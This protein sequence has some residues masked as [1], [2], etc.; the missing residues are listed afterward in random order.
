[1]REKGHEVR[2]RARGEMAIIYIGAY[3]K[4]ASASLC[5]WFYDKTLHRMYVKM[6]FQFGANGYTDR[7]TFSLAI[8]LFFISIFMVHLR[9]LFLSSRVSIS[10]SAKS[11]KIL[12]NV[13]FQ[14]NT[15]YDQ[16]RCSVSS[17]KTNS[18]MKCI[19]DGEAM[20]GHIL[21]LVSYALQLYLIREFFSFTGNYNHTL[22]EPYEVM[23]FVIFIMIATAVHE[24]SCS[25]FYTCVFISTT[26]ICLSGFIFYQ[27]FDSNYR[28]SS[29]K[30]HDI[31]QDQQRLSKRNKN[32]E[33]RFTI[34]VS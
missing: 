28:Y 12:P 31:S 14:C 32:H 22:T 9:N 10:P 27:F 2:K 11:H 23:V 30:V 29:R 15:P 24:S 1:M 20:I 13:L 8:I 17:N 33:L 4:F 6:K 21:P 16:L 25:H 5:I 7:R 34:P 18:P 19:A 26:G 3:I